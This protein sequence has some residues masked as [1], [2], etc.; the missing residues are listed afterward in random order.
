MKNNKIEAIKPVYTDTIN[1]TINGADMVINCRKTLPFED[2]ARLVT[3]VAYQV[4]NDES[5]YCPFV[6]DIA[7]KKNIIEYFTDFVIDGVTEFYNSGELNTLVKKVIG[8]VGESSD[9]NSVISNIDKLIEFKKLQLANKSEFDSLCKTL[10]EVILRLE[11]KFGRAI[12]PKE[13]KEAVKKLNS[14][15]VDEKSLIDAIVDKLPAKPSEESNSNVIPF[16][17]E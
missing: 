7:L 10:S 12:N 5:G 17:A 6:Y 4:V 1:C 9:Y 13:I 3:D 15:N 8:V 2:Y 16:A 14:M 11:K